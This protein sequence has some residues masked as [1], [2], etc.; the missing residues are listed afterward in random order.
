MKK[1][2]LTF[3]NNVKPLELKEYKYWRK[4]LPK[5]LKV[6]AELE[7]NLRHVSGNCKGLNDRCICPKLQSGECIPKCVFLNNGEC[8][9]HIRNINTCKNATTSCDNSKCPTCNNFEF[10]CGKSSCL[11]YLMECITCAK[12]RNM[13]VSCNNRYD[14]TNSPDSIRALVENSLGA[15]QN[16]GN[17][18]R[19][20]VLQVVKDGSLVNNGLEIPTVGRRFDFETF[21]KMFKNILTVAK[22]NGGYADPR[23]SFHVHILN[24]YYTKVNNSHGR[25]RRPDE[26][27]SL[28]FTSFENKLP[29][30]ILTNIIQLWRQYETAIY[31][32]SCGNP[33]SSHLTRWEKFRVSMLDFS[34]I[35]MS[36]E[37]IMSKISNLVGKKRYGSL[38]LA[39]TKS[40]GSRLHLECRVC[41]MIMSESYMTAMCCL[42]YSIILKAV[43]ISCY[44]LLN[45]ENSTWLEKEKKIKNSIVNGATRQY[46]DNRLSDTSSLYKYKTYL[47]EKSIELINLLSPILSSFEP[48]EKLLM[49][50]AKNPIGYRLEKAMNDNDLTYLEAINK[51]NIEKDLVSVLDNNKNEINEEEKRLLKTIALN[52]IYGCDTI[53]A[54]IAET[55]KDE[56]TTIDKIKK[57]IND[58]QDDIYWKNSIGSYV[59]MEK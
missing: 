14:S 7:F 50:I 11:Y 26:D 2:N 28:N 57:Y 45:V 48:A 31:W 32:M 5:V 40:D 19:N 42:F 24:E 10:K 38:N 1:I 49:S 34:P 16:F 54:W 47:Q 46:G 29:D 53:E 15:T 4:L 41:D 59:C 39:N 18:G 9:L 33:D 12:P 20:G 23:C 30:I 44:G 8:S 6:G 55:A 21:R 51:Y 36:I 43:D 27:V 56:N 58:L 3:Y 13:C 17:V 25:R 52:K 35:F 22:A 37:T